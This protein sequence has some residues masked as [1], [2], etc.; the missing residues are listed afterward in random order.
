MLTQ[1]AGRANLKKVRVALP[2]SL[3]LDPDNAESDGL[4]SFVEGSTPDPQCPAS[5]VVGKATAI[6]PIL[7]EPLSGPVFFVKN[8]RKD[9]KSGRSIKT[10]PK[11]VIPLTGENGVKL[12]L[13]GTSDVVDDKLVTTFNNI[14]DAQVSSF[15]MDINGGKK[16]ILVVSSADIC[17]STQIAEQ[18]VDGQNNK[19]ADADVYIQTP[20]C[21]TKILARPLARRRS[22]E[23]RWPRRRQGHGDRQGH[24]EDDQDHRQVDRRDDHRQAHRQV[25]A[26]RVQ[27]EVHQGQGRG[28]MSGTASYGH[29]SR[30]AEPRAYRERLI[31]SMTVLAADRG[32]HGVTVERVCEHAGVS[33]VTF[34][35]FFSDM[36]D[37]FAGAVEEAHEALWSDVERGIES[38]PA[39]D[40]A[41]ALSAAITA[42]LATLEAH[43]KAA[44]LCIVE[45]MNGVPRAVAARKQLVARLAALIPVDVDTAPTP[46]AP[47]SVGALWELVLQ[48]LTGQGETRRLTELAGSSIFLVL[49]PYVGRR[50]AMQHAMSPPAVRR[51]AGA[52]PA[53]GAHRRADPAGPQHAA[54]LGRSSRGEQR[55]DQPRRRRAARQP[56]EPPPPPPRAAGPRPQPPRR[57]PQRLVAHR[58]GRE[59]RGAGRRLAGATS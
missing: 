45:P 56:D 3:A 31:A 21:P 37:C 57:P 17:K 25:E 44:W 35:E 53:D 39:G 6:S 8:E 55:R 5:S 41:L 33:K 9:P 13:T 49:A 43:P 14:P 7:H 11:L 42:F 26:R 1:P 15:K 18:Q 32:R 4:C 34:Y 58:A 36:D 38:V 23:D 29:R 52:A 54:V 47:G 20:S 50:A 22:A 19:A 30:L 46:T 48:H 28:G 59:D 2:L 40:W 16:G 51:R 10:T 12:T 27:G 24:Q